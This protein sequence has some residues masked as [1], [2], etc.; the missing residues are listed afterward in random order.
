MVKGKMMELTPANLPNHLLDRDSIVGVV[1]KK[2]LVHLPS[3]IW[4]KANVNPIWKTSV[5]LSEVQG[6]NH[7]VCEAHLQKERVAKP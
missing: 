1:K 6:S 4:H 7:H 3:P 5:Q 2:I